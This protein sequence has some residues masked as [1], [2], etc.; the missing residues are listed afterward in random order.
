MPNRILRNPALLILGGAEAISL[1][2][3]WITMMAVLAILIF[4]G[5]GGALQSS[6]VFIAGLLPALLVS[7][8]AGWLCDRFERKKLMIA[9]QLLS[10]LVVGGLVFT[11]RVELIY[12]LLAL[13]AVCLSVMAPARQSSVADIVAHE[14]LA[15]ANAF[16]QQLTGVV[17]IGAPVFAGFLLGFLDPHTAILLDVA[18]FVL[19]AG[20]LSLLPGLPPHSSHPPRQV[21]CAGTA[22][23]RRLPAL[24]GVLRQAPQLYVLFLAISLTVFV[25]TGFDV[26]APLYFRDLL[27]EGEQFY[28]FSIGLVG[29]GTLAGALFLMLRKR[30]V[31]PWYDF[32][33]G[34]ILL[35]F[36]AMC[37]ALAAR[38]ADLTAARLLVLAGCLIGGIGCALANVQANTLLQ[39][40]SPAA[41]LGRISG[42]QQSMMVLGQLLGVIAT[43]VLVPAFLSVA[44]FFSISALALMGVA[45]FVVLQMRRAPVGLPETRPP[46][47]CSIEEGMG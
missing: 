33:A 20:L 16:L 19:A 18:T 31:N 45:A 24:L 7:P 8:A 5:N 44:P 32:I 22:R 12:A 29:V 37:M 1:I 2:G 17:K 3:D 15:R 4:R 38:L 30:A 6:G 9:S 41:Y 23:V 47:P 27:G 25:I 13:E 43:P 34:V 10:A 14:D 28:G 42:M 36:I 26:L 40:L 35:S 21:S 39:T 46:T 11:S